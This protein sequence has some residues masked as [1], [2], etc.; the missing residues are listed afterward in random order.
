MTDDLDDCQVFLSD[1]DNHSSILPQIKH[2]E[3]LE[4]RIDN[5][6]KQ[7]EFAQLIHHFPRLQEVVIIADDLHDS[8]K[9]LSDYD[10][11]ERMVEIVR[12]H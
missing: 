11:T 1:R 7:L 4:I 6:E 2:L 5:P 12:T 8:V 9:Q 10:L 3:K